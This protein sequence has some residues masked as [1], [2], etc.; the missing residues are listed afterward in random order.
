[1][2]H[3]YSKLYLYDKHVMVLK[4]HAKDAAG[5]I[6]HPVPLLGEKGIREIIHLVPLLGEKVIREIIQPVNQELH[7]HLI[8]IKAT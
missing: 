3:F 5:Q 6:I 2:I 7:T 4:V 8:C 1:M